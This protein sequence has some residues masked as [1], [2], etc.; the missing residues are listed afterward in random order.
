MIRSLQS[1]L[2]H[3]AI[4]ITFTA[5][6]LS[7]ALPNKPRIVHPA[8]SIPSTIV[9]TM[10]TASTLFFGQKVDGYAQVTANDN[11]ALTGTVIFYDGT[12]NICTI[13]VEQNTNCPATIGSGFLVGRHA[14]SAAYFGDQTHAAAVSATAIVTISPGIT[15]ALLTTSSNPAPAGQ[16]LI[17]IASLQSSYAVPVGSVTFFDGGII[18][19]TEALDG[20]GHA[21]L[22]TSSLTP[23]T[24]IIGLSYAAMQNFTAVTASPI[25][26]IVTDP[27]LPV[28]TAVMISSNANPA[29]A[30]QALTLSATVVSTSSPLR[31]P[32]GLLTFKDGANTLGA[33]T[34]DPSGLASFQTSSLAP[35]THSITASY[36]GDGSSAASTSAPLSQT[37]TPATTPANASFVIGVGSTTLP[38]GSSINIAV[39][40]APV[41]G[42]NQAVQ[43]SCSNLPYEASCTFVTDTVAAGGGTTTF[44]LTT[45]SPRDCG[46]AAGY[47]QSA[48]NGS[49]ALPYAAPLLA[50]VLI[51]LLPKRRRAWKSLLTLIAMGGFLSITGCGECTDLGTRPGSY[52]LKIVGRSMGANPVTVTQN[53]QITVTP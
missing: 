34:L 4:A 5:L 48:S 51:F 40:V 26:Q 46:A 50:G 41:N 11:S 13:T 47:N 21:R 17:L 52:T 31:T 6:P 35:G 8:A 10:T 32:T 20:T 24:H 2:T 27:S 18:L 53:V 14:L 36:T 1:R 45:L 38:T 39:K 33:A 37:V 30:G 25:T 15:T 3:L 43:L 28:A 9:F 44:R 16:S 22:L 49:Q 29:T 23:G 42:F 12:T 19:G 7:A